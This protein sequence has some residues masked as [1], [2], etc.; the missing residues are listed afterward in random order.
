M[1]KEKTKIT[2]RVMMTLIAIVVAILVTFFV[3]ATIDAALPDVEYENCYQLREPVSPGEDPINQ[4]KGQLDDTKV[5][6]CYDKQ[7]E[8]RK[9]NSLYA[10]L[11]ASVIGVIAVVAGLYIPTNTSAAS[12]IAGGIL[13]GGLFTIFTGTI[14][15]WDGLIEI[16]KPIVL[17][18]ELVIV[19]WVAFKKLN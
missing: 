18:I 4:T 16:A 6:E 17:L 8:K 1:K 19:I 15:G 7:D 11:I 13:L 14:R 12:A 9:T 5:Q 2:S 10:F 3:H